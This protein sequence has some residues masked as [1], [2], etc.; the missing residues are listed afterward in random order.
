MKTSKLL[1]ATLREAPADAETISHQLML[2]AGLIR[3]IAS[4][5]YSWLPVGLRVLR[6]VENIVRE[7]M[8]A[9]GAQELLMPSVQPAELWHE[10]GRWDKYGPELL[11]FND[12]HEREFCLG[13]THEEVITDLVRHEIRSYKQ[14]PSIFYQIQTK[15]RD[16]IR[17][18]FGVMRAREFI[19]KDAYSFHLNQESLR[20]TYETMFQTY[21]HIFD[22]LGLHYRAVVADSGNIGG[23]SSHEFHVLA[24][25]GEDEI[26]FTENGKFAANIEM[27]NLN[28][29]EEPRKKPAKQLEQIS[30]PTQHTIEEVSNFFNIESNQCIKTLIVHGS[31][32]DLI[33]L[34]LRGDHHLN[35]IKAEN[36]A[37]IQK[38]LKF[39]SSS[40]IENKIG[41]NTG[42]IGPVNLDISVIVDF[43][44]AAVSDFICGANQEG[45]HLSGVNWGR[46]I[47]EPHVEDLRN[48]TEGETAPEKSGAVKIA[49]GIEV[50]HIFQLGTKYSEAMKVN[51][52]DETG[53][54][55]TLEM[56]CYGIGISRIVAAA[57]EQN[58]DDRGIIWPM[59]IAPYEL[60][61]VPINMHKS[62]R[63]RDAVTQIYNSMSSAGIEVLVD[64]RRERPGV[65]FADMELL[66][67][68][69]RIVLSDKGLDSNTVEYKGRQDSQSILVPIDEILNIIKDK[70]TR[71]L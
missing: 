44:A 63:L 41:C 46:D 21:S 20:E 52:L 25:S 26:V 39:A 30:T 47:P 51:C 24:D 9:A 53:R 43:S 33:A 60:A 2:R 23:D 67:I 4:G 12:R 32:D 3:Q 45:F 66:G 14:L 37:G 56:G 22:R 38:P 8:D 16:E 1:L 48:I 7:E 62:Q 57:I 36:L 71:T 59:T 15:F 40:E 31:N 49:R 65:M 61:I 70:M 34:V 68:P 17:P 13:P 28:P 64:D 58:H 35:R 18:R 11:R 5:I 6:K 10:S 54:A 55:T 69:H 42:F 50:G 27:V 19:M 29:P